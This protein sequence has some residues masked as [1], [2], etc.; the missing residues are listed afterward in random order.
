MYRWLIIEI[1]DFA[2]TKP[3]KLTDLTFIV[4]NDTFNNNNNN[5]KDRISKIIIFRFQR[6][7]LTFRT[8]L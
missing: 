5:K 8:F 7:D 2:S 3:R 6:N 4:E 1:D